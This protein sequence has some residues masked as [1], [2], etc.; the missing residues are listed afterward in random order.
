MPDA[1]QQREGKGGARCGILEIYKQHGGTAVEI[2]EGLLMLQHHGQDS[3][4]MVTTDWEE[5]HGSRPWAA[6][7]A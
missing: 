2:Y 7:E 3:A 6:A 5:F 1:Q 4:G